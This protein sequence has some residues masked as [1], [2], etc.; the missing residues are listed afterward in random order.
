MFQISRRQFCQFAAAAAAT[1]GIPSFAA[2]AEKS[3]VTIAVGGK[4]LYYYLPMAIADWMGFFKDEG[5]DVGTEPL[6]VNQVL[7]QAGRLAVGEYVGGNVREV[8]VGSQTSAHMEGETDAV[9]RHIG[10]ML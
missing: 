4:N 10:T 2:A 8:I 5:V 1:S 7:D 6:V 9:S 3:S